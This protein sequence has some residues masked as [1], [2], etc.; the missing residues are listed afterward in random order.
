VRDEPLEIAWNDPV[1]A[2]EAIAVAVKAHVIAGS[3]PL[4]AFTTVWTELQV[5]IEYRDKYWRIAVPLIAE[6]ALATG[7]QPSLAGTD[8]SEIDLEE[9]DLRGFDFSGANL[10]GAYL[11]HAR[12]DGANF[13]GADLTDTDLAGAS[14][15]GATMPDGSVHA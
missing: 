7:Q 13:T 11:A 9:G 10:A 1:V 8:L 6:H 3:A 2:F 15:T 4:E 12:L 14:L 5:P